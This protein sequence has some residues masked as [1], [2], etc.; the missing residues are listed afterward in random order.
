MSRRC[1]V[2]ASD[3]TRTL[4]GFCQYICLSLLSI[5]ILEN[6]F[7]WLLLLCWDYWIT[8]RLLIAIASNALVC[9]TSFFLQDLF[10]E[11][12]ST[13]FYL[14]HWMSTF[15]FFWTPAFSWKGSHETDTVRWSVCQFVSRPFLEDFKGQKLRKPNILEL[16]TLIFSTNTFSY[17]VLRQCCKKTLHNYLGGF[18]PPLLFIHPLF[19]NLLFL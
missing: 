15:L 5:S 19:K 3:I 12:Q 1:L 16:F 11:V 9:G 4:F 10:C 6:G 14:F 8:L 7:I 13:L 17:L 2:G 18:I